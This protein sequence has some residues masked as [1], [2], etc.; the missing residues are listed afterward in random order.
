VLVHDE[1]PDVHPEDLRTGRVAAP[2]STSDFDQLDS[3]SS[4]S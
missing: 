2:V 1:N 3:P 4:R